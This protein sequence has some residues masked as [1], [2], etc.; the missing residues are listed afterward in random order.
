M[1]HYITWKIYQKLLG[2]PPVDWFARVP[3]NVINVFL[4][5]IAFKNLIIIG[6][7]CNKFLQITEMPNLLE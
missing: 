1:L 3:L 6:I 5:G 7:T 4:I 2:A